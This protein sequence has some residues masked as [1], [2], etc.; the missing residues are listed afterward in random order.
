MGV[1]LSNGQLKIA[2]SW[3]DGLKDGSGNITWK[4]AKEVC[5]LQ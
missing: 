2:G 5:S 1:L 3:K 4:M